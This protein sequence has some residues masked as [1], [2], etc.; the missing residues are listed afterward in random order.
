MGEL[1]I[2]GCVFAAFGF[3]PNMIQRRAVFAPDLSV[4][5]FKAIAKHRRTTERAQTLLIAPK[6]LKLI[7]IRRAKRLAHSPSGTAHP[8]RAQAAST[9]FRSRHAM[10][11][12]P[13][14]PGTGVIDPATAAQLL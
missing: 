5:R 3:R 11:I 7:R 10:V 9:V 8:R 1:Q 2:I 12:G 6:T 4:R 13:T 14:P